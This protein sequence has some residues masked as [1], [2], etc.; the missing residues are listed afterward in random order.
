MAEIYHENEHQP[1]FENT[2]FRFMAGGKHCSLPLVKFNEIY[3]I[4]DDPREVS[5]LK[6]FPPAKIFWDLIA[7]GDFKP[8]TVYQSHIRNPSVWIIAKVL[9]NLL[10]AKDKTSKVTNGEL[11]MLYSG[12]EDQIRA[13][14]GGIPITKCHILRDESTYMFQDKEGTQLFCKLP[15]TEIKSMDKFENIRFLPE[16][17][18]LCDNLLLVHQEDPGT[19]DIEDVT[20]DPNYDLEDIEDGFDDATVSRKERTCKSSLS[21]QSIAQARNQLKRH[22]EESGYRGTG[23]LLGNPGAGSQTDPLP[24]SI[25]IVLSI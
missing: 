23:V 14:R 6:S 5:L 22:Q 9:S 10:F 16:Q 8:R 18:Q 2:H 24:T 21:G 4:S 15:Q 11:Q 3:D 12:L 25:T 13:A 20:P 1:T 19:E 17:E 7:S